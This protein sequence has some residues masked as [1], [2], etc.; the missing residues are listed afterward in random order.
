MLLIRWN[1]VYV[2]SQSL[3]VLPQPRRHRI[4]LMISSFSVR[5]LIFSES[6]SENPISTQTYGQ[7]HEP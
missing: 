6:C 1:W 7:R 5:F 3:L 2:G 4:L